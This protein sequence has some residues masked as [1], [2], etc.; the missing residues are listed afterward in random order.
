MI[1]ANVLYP[2]QLYTKFDMEY[3]L[4][5]HLTMLRWL[6]RTSLKGVSVE[7]GVSGLT[8]DSPLPTLL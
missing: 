8:S 5:R 4:N 3:Y 7:Q 6:L 1:K 2:M